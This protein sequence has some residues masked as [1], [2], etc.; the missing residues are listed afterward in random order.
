ML[1]VTYL[2]SGLYLE[3][4]QETIEDWIALRV[5]LALRLGQRLV[6]ERSTASLLLPID[7]VKTAGLEAMTRH[8]EAVTITVCDANDCEVCLQGSWISSST[9][10]TEGVFIAA[11]NPAIE[12]VLLKLW[13]TSQAKA[14]SIWR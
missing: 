3:S 7:L 8:E 13:Q 2:E 12:Q 1:K 4:L 10:E 6:V 14:S 9:D 11:L 5:L